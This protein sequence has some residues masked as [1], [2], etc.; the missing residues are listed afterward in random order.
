MNNIKPNVLI[1]KRY[2]EIGD[3]SSLGPF[4]KQ[5]NYIVLELETSHG[6]L[7]IGLA[8]DNPNK[9]SLIFD[10][11]N[12]CTGEPLSEFCEE[13]KKLCIER[14]DE[15]Y[16]DDMREIEF[17]KILLDMHEICIR[18]VDRTKS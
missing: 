16:H 12:P 6:C 14:K 3:E 2:G 10:N 4:L 13:I 15:W 1:V 5:K 11:V 8:V 7:G 9:G 17:I 18:M